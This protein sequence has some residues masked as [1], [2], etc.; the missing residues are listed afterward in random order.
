VSGELP[1]NVKFIGREEK[2]DEIKRYIKTNAPSYVVIIEICGPPGVGKR[3]LAN[4]VAHDLLENP[5]KF[6]L[7]FDLVL[8]GENLHYKDLYNLLGKWLREYL[9][10]SKKD[11]PSSP[12]RRIDKYRSLIKNKA[13]LMVL[14]NP[15]S[16]KLVDRLLPNR[17]PCVVLITKCGSLALQ[18]SKQIKLEQ[19][20][21]SDALSL[22][23]TC[24]GEPQRVQNELTAAQKIIEYCGYL[25]LASCLAASLLKVNHH[26]SLANFSKKLADEEQRLKKLESGD[27]SRPIHSCFELIYRELKD[28]EARLFRLLSLLPKDFS[29]SVAKEIIGQPN[30]E[31]SFDRLVALNLLEKQDNPLEKKDLGERY[32]F[33]NLLRLYA[34]EKLE[35]AKEEEKE[36]YAK[37]RIIKHFL[38]Q[39]EYSS[40]CL[41][42]DIKHPE[43]AKNLIS[44]HRVEL[45][46]QDEQDL[47]KEALDWFEKELP[48]LLE[49]KDW[50]VNAKD[51]EQLVKLSLY[52]AGFLDR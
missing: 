30:A 23:E 24:I 4:Y 35:Q 31:D 21:E 10:L 7:E 42:D 25:P 34:R 8:F 29:K 18:N 52:L 38:S 48:T 40:N 3:A 49:I 16:K 5:S 6:D 20:K 50:L 14:H 37:Q 19:L 43:I 45:Q 27:E 2:K 41:I 32:Q 15:E 9:N 28:D 13:V 1:R 12:E 47:E 17:I 51:W 22:L 36:E 46:S 26:W 11:I 33:C 39:A 44:V